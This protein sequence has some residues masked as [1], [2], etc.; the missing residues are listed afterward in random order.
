MVNVIFKPS[1]RK[2][3]KWRALFSDGSIVDFGYKGM[4]DYTIHKDKA[5][6]ERFLSR[7]ARLIEREKNNP[8]SPITLATLILWNKPTIQASIRDY[9]NRFNL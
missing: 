2:G 6:K 4:E 8:K 3:K 1:P 7:F 5:R 9:K